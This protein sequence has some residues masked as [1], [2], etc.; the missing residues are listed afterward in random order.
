M[1]KIKKIKSHRRTSQRLFMM[2]KK[3]VEALH[4]T[5]TFRH[6]PTILQFHRICQ[7]MRISRTIILKTSSLVNKK[8]RRKNLEMGKQKYSILLER[9]Y[10]NKQVTK[11]MIR[12]EVAR[13]K[14]IDLTLSLFKRESLKIKLNHL[15]KEL[16][17]FLHR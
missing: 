3:V 14:G 8:Q 10:L 9:Q 6:Q 13:L 17:L 5:Q 12:R 16:D 1:L 7:V 15:R 11:K 4:L 2:S